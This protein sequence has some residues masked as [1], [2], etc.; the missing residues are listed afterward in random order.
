MSPQGCRRS[1]GRAA[2]VFSA[3]REHA[4]NRFFAAF[5]DAG[6]RQ[7]EEHRRA[8]ACLPRGGE[9]AGASC[10]DARPAV[11]AGQAVGRGMPFTNMSADPEQE[12]FADGIAEDVITALSRFPRFF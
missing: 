6:P 3:V 1:R 9:C 11:T 8:D 5:T 12:F 10:P 4:G 7:V 2:S